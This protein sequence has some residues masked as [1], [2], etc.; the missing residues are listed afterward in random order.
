M[1]NCLQRHNE[2]TSVFR[3]LNYLLP[4]IY[5]MCYFASALRNRSVL[6]F[7]FIQTFVVE[8]N[9]ESD[10][11]FSKEDSVFYMLFVWFRQNFYFFTFNTMLHD[12]CVKSKRFLFAFSHVFLKSYWLH[13]RH[14]ML[15]RKPAVRDCELPKTCCF[16]P[17]SRIL[18][19]F[20]FTSS[21]LP[22]FYL[23]DHCSSCGHPTNILSFG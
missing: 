17:F 23:V 21:L 5:A 15:F 8:F 7:F 16:T 11:Y 13:C 19:T 2:T 12:F 6:R 18:S 9:W 10:Q 14:L 22:K 1:T 3:I 4:K 20:S